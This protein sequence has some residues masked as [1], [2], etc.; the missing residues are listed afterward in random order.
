MD[1]FSITLWIIA[2]GGGIFVLGFI[3]ILIDF[4]VSLFGFNQPPSKETLKYIDEWRKSN[5]A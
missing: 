5:K 4:I 2:I 1:T 3:A